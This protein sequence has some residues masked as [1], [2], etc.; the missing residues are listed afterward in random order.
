MVQILI[1]GWTRSILC[2][3]TVR[4]LL[5]RITRSKGVTTNAMDLSMMVFRQDP[6]GPVNAMS[7]VNLSVPFESVVRTTSTI[8]LRT[9][10]FI[11]DGL[12]LRIVHIKHEYG[13]V[14]TG[15]SLPCLE[16]FPGTLEQHIDGGVVLTGFCVSRSKCTSFLVRLVR[17]ARYL[18]KNR[19]EGPGGGHGNSEKIFSHA[20]L[21][22]ND[23]VEMA[24]HSSSLPRTSSIAVYAP[25]GGGER[26]QMRCIYLSFALRIL[27]FMPPKLLSTILLLLT[28]NNCFF[29][30]ESKVLLLVLVFGTARCCRILFVLDKL[31]L[32]RYTDSGI[33]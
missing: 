29:F 2:R 3:P 28:S 17:R 25:L 7:C 18:R 20:L 13:K 8:T 19:V 16:Q 9:P 22:H 15:T 26:R 10:A 23:D 5:V 11:V 1:T 30:S 21:F 31:T 32:L 14:S 12:S 24:H 4:I 27:A 33:C 6:D